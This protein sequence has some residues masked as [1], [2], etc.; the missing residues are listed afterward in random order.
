VTERF[1]ILLNLMF[2]FQLSAVAFPL[3]SLLCYPGGGDDDDDNNGNDDSG[4]N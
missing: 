1:G 3:P 2:V 4:D